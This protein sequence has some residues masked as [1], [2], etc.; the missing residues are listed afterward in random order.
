MLTAAVVLLALCTLALVASS[1]TG[2]YAQPEDSTQN[3]VTAV[4]EAAAPAAA[5]ATARG[6]VS[7]GGPWQE[8]GFTGVA[9]PATGCF[10]ADPAGPGCVPSSGGN[11]VFADAP[12][13]TFV[14]P[15]GGTVLTVTDA[16]LRGDVFRVFDFGAPIGDTSAVAVGGACGDDP[17]PCLAD[18]LVSSGVF[19]LAAGPHS[20]TIAPTVSPFGG[21]AAYFGLDVGASIT[22]KL[23]EEIVFPG[24]SVDIEKTVQTPVIPPIV[25]ICLQQDETGSMS[26]DI[27][28]LKALA[29]PGGPLIAALDATGSDYATCVIGFRDFAQN[30]WGDPGDWVYRRLADVTAGGGGFVAGVPLLTANGGNDGPEAQ[31]EALHYEATPGHACIDSDGDTVCPNNQDTPVAQQP[32]WRPDAQR[33][34]LLATDANCHVP[35]DAGGWPGDADL[36]TTIAALNSAGII[37]IGLVPGGLGVSPCVDSLA[38][39]TGGSVQDTGA[40]GEDVVNA[41]LTALGEVQVEVSMVSS[42]TA[43]ISVSFAPPSQTVTSGDPA[44]FTETI[45]VAPNAPGG[46]Y[47]C[48]DWALID[49]EPMRDPAGNIIKE[50]KII[51]VPEGFL[52]GGGQIDNGRGKNK[53]ER[54]NASGNVGFL[55]D[56]SLVGQWNVVFHDVTNSSV[57]LDKAHFHSTAITALQFFHDGGA[58]PNPPPANAN[59][60]YFAATGRLGQDPGWTLEVC[61]ADRGE[62]G[63]KGT[64]SLRLRLTNPGGVVVYDSLSDFAPEDNTLTGICANRHKLDTGNYQIHSG[65]KGP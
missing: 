55:A 5:E 28:T 37:V 48:D 44:V 52:T 59:A 58:G 63:S 31:L 46:T 21:G 51:K 56:F 20:I 53:A 30:G 9:V 45:S 4:P 12:P 60:A 54:L 25:D 22:P 65:V 23:V 13:W 16:F 41:I 26:D 8:F 35:G 18:P 47:E 62:P 34:S 6:P 43:P 19:P 2:V 49:G 11:S 24:G 3:G 40:S 36:A 50:H 29:G 32:T 38:A 1:G 27:A 14:A 64:D 42:C 61:L 15:A 33:V 7:I 10:P 39:G 57:D 17:V